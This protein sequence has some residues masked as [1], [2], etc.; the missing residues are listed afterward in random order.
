MRPISMTFL[1]AAL[2]ACTVLAQDLPKM[3]IDTSRITVSGVSSG[4][5]MAIQARP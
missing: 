5:A 4:G 1:F 3:N 2:M